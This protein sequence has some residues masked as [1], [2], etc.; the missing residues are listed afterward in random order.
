M[1]A[2]EVKRAVEVAVGDKMGWRVCKSSCDF[3]ASIFRICEN[4]ALYRHI[5]TNV[6][7]NLC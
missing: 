3:S 1:V 4:K 2:L 6:V 7:S 5:L